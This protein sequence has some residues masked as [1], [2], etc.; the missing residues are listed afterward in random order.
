MEPINGVVSLFSVGLS[1]VF[2]WADPVASKKTP[3]AMNARQTIDL[4]ILLFM[5]SPCDPINMRP[6]ATA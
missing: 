5:V 6:D 2:L 1:S 4:K 3:G